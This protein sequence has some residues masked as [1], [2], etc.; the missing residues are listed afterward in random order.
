V[1]DASVDIEDLGKVW[2]L[3]VEDQFLQ[4]SNLANFFECED[5]ILLVALYC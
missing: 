4:F 2:L 1:R 3:H 5:F